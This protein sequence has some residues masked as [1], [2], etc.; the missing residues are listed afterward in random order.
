MKLLYNKDNELLEGKIMDITAYFE[1]GCRLCPRMC[2]A[3]RFNDEKNTSFCRAGSDISAARASL[4]FWEEPCLS[5]D[6]GSGTIFFSGCP[7]R[8]EFCQNREISHTLKGKLIS[9]ERLCEIFFELKSQGAHNINL[10]SPTP[11]IPHIVNAI[12]LAKKKGF[13]LPFVFNSSGYERAESLKM[14]DGLIDIYLPDFKYMSSELAQKYS[15]AAN[16]PEMAKNALDE[17]VKQCMVPQ[18]DR[19]GMMK[20][21]VIVRHLVLPGNTEDSKAVIGYLYGTYKDKIYLSIM[22]QYTPTGELNHPE[23]CRKITTEEYDEVVDFAVD[24]GVTQGF[25]QE[26]DSAE[27]S[28]IPIFDMRGI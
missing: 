26:G 11:Y 3:Y 27:E 9:F 18:F 1:K 19:D 24:L 15:L 2:N 17:M 4:H 25:L 8:C 16:Y 7:L 28:F 12:E 14:L 22:S 10:V 23:L 13:D 5:G 21:G 6:K 20:K